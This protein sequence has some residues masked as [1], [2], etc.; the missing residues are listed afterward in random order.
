MSL[1]QRYSRRDVLRLSAAAILGT[2]AIALIYE[3]GKRPASQPIL[4]T[5]RPLLMPGW[6]ETSIEE[7]AM[8]LDPEKGHEYYLRSLCTHPLFSDKENGILHFAYTDMFQR[9]KEQRAPKRLGDTFVDHVTYATRALQRYGNI[10]PTEEIIHAAIISFAAVYGPYFNRDDIIHRFGVA[11]DIVDT[12]PFWWLADAP[13]VYPVDSSWCNG[14]FDIKVRCRGGD[15]AVH[16]AQYLFL[17]HQTNYL[18]TYEIHDIDTI[19]LLAK[20]WM[21]VSLWD[22]TEKKVKRLTDMAQIVWELEETKVWA[23][24]VITR[25]ITKVKRNDSIPPSGFVDSL[26]HLDFKANTLGVRTAFA[27]AKNSNNPATF[28]PIIDS[29][30]SPEIYAIPFPGQQLPYTWKQVNKEKVV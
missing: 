11:K 21:N 9:K 3:W 2:S 15:R 1:E 29:L 14:D 5:Q 23:K 6:I 7:K 25:V 20:W 18:L 16:F 24:R 4:E 8:F 17:A 27:L 28:A 26:V 30:N 10:P 12:P 19:P 22:N 13:T